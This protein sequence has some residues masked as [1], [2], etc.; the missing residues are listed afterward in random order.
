MIEFVTTLNTLDI[1]NG[2]PRVAN[3][4]DDIRAAPIVAASRLRGKKR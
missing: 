4:V 3:A 2:F 1:V